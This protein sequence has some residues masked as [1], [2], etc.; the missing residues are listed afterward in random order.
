M[1][2]VT[3]IGRNLKALPIFNNV[4]RTLTVS[5]LSRLD[6]HNINSFGK[7]EEVRATDCSS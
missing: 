7:P 5:G 1:V 2:S 3:R 4:R 6:C